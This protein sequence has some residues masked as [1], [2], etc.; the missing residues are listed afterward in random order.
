[1]LIKD[2]EIA[3]IQTLTDLDVGTCR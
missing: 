3:D 1:M 2:D